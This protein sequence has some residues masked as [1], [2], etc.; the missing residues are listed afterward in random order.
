MPNEKDEHHV[1]F[2]GMNFES[3][4]L[5]NI[6]QFEGAGGKFP[7]LTQILDFYENAFDHNSAR[8]EGKIIPAQGVDQE[9]DDANE[10]LHQIKRELDDYL[11][12]QKQHFGCE[13]KYWGTG[14]NRYQLEIPLEKV[15][16]AGTE[17]TLASGTKKLKR[18]TTDET[19]DFLARQTAREVEKEAALLD[20]QRKLFYQFSQN[21]EVLRQAIG[22]VSSLDALLSLAAYSSSLEV[23][24]F[25]TFVEREVPIVDVKMGSHPCMDIGADSFIPN[26][27]LLEDS[28]CL[29][30]LTGIIIVF[31]FTFP[32]MLRFKDP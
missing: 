25:P 15:K 16:R 19:K 17:Y 3:K 29:L 31:F 23:S 4:I 13:V 7:D 1:I 9:L 8:K 2:Q 32:S 24:C 22:C 12:N 27:L 26:D 18:Y 20:I 5:Q 10:Q 30:V 6:T 14:K 11:K 21:A 28:K